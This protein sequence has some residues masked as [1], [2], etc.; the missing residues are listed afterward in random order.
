MLILQLPFHVR[1][2]VQFFFYKLY[3]IKMDYTFS[4]SSLF[5][6]ESFM[7]VGIFCNNCFE[8]ENLVKC[9][10]R[11]YCNIEFN[12]ICGVNALSG[13]PLLL[14]EHPDYSLPESCFRF[15]PFPWIYLIR[16]LKMSS[17][18]LPLCLPLYIVVISQPLAGGL[19]I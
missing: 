18:F 12:F 13:Y 19:N 8:S 15:L 4:L 1:H 11:F 17:L 10:C 6:A 7:Q 5:P 14:L 16:S 3:T 9:D 2:F